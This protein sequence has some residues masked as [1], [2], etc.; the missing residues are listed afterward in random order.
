LNLCSTK[1]AS[2]IFRDAAL[3][4]LTGEGHM[5]LVTEQALSSTNVPIGTLGLRQL[6]A[7][8]EAAHIY[9]SL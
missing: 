2:K 6:H 4:N 8:N 9:D 1:D 3:L 5:W 7:T